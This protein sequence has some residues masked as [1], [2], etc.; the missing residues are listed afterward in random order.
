[1]VHKRKK[2]NPFK[3]GERVRL[4]KTG[5]VFT[6]YGVYSPTEVSLSLRDYPDTEQDWTTNIKEI[7]RV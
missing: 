7:E 4:K 3:V 1:M 6:I 5:E 2:V